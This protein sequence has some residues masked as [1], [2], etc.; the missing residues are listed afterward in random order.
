MLAYDGQGAPGLAQDHDNQLGK[1]AI[2]DDGNARI[3]RYIQL[4]QDLA[5]RSERLGKYGIEVTD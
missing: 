5:G 3:S 2:A 4:V 1:L